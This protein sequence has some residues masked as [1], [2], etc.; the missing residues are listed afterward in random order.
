[1]IALRSLSVKS[2]IPPHRFGQR[3]R[4]APRVI[5]SE[6]R[7]TLFQIMR[8]CIGA[9]AQSLC[10]PSRYRRFIALRKLRSVDRNRYGENVGIE[11]ASGHSPRPVELEIRRKSAAEN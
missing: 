11:K 6:N 5:F 4:D 3:M 10:E 1:M 7:C 2:L 8:Y 9:R